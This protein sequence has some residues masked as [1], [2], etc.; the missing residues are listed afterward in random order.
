MA[1]DKLIRGYLHDAVTDDA[2][3]PLLLARLADVLGAEEAVLGGSTPGGGLQ[4]YSPRT[5]P[6]LVDVYLETYHQQ[7]S[8]L[9]S[10]FRPGD[11]GVVAVEHLPQFEAF[12]RSDFYHLWCAPQRFNYAFGFQLAT[13]TGW[14]GAVMV[15]TRSPVSQ[16][17]TQMLATL[18]RDLRH[19]VEMGQL[20]GQ[21]RA[22]HGM[23]LDALDAA[24]RGGILL[25]RRG[26]VIAINRLA[27]SMI[28]A[29]RLSIRNQ[30]LKGLDVHSDAMLGTLLARCLGESNMAGSHG[31]VTLSDGLIAR[32]VPYPGSLALPAN[33]RPAALLLL[34]DPEANVSRKIETIRQAFGLTAAETALVLAL[35]RTGSRKLAAAQRGVSDKTARAQ[36]DSIFDK[37]EVRR[38]AEL[39]RLV[40]AAR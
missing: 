5:D 37:T 16:Q 35:V 13:S 4:S 27:A 1:F 25:E 20:I 2:V 15:N 28:E 17:Q 18:S 34:D 39:V 14:T 26:Q 11:Q 32:F 24:D 33:Q 36:L 38:Q 3:W 22:A 6:G 40:M 30:Q 23:A 29:G 7:N 19:C 9:R 10:M 21:L 12:Q 8:I 31:S